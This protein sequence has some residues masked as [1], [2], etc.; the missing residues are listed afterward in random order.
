ML[1]QIIE[2]IVVNRQETVCSLNSCA[3]KKV[4]TTVMVFRLVFLHS[5]FTSLY[6]CFPDLQR[7]VLLFL[8]PISELQ[9]FN[10][11]LDYL[12]RI[13]NPLDFD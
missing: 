11:E 10:T 6:L 3:K 4:G 5:W 13:K 9:Q 8:L 2:H 7:A 12:I 1:E